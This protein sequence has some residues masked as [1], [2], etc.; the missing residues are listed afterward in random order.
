LQADVAVMALF[1]NTCLQA[2]GNLDSGFCTSKI[3]HFSSLPEEMKN[4]IS[5]QG[6]RCHLGE[7]KGKEVLIA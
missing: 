6:E 2:A 1:C 5:S 3:I 4:Y 7:Q